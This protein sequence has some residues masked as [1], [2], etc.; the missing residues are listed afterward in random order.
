MRL[1]ITCLLPS[2]SSSFRRF[3]LYLFV[4]TLSVFNLTFAAELSVSAA[5]G[6]REFISYLGKEFENKTGSRVVFNFSSSG[7][8][9]NQIEFG[10][11]VDVYISASD[12][13]MNYLVSKGIVDKNTVFP[14]AGTELAVVTFVKSGITSLQE[15]KRIAIGDELAPVGRYAVEALKN[16]GLYGKLKNRFVFAPTVRHIAVWVITGNAD[17]GVV[18]YSDYLKFKDRLKL[19][20]ILPK[21]SHSPILFYIGLVRSTHQR[22]LA[23]KFEKFLFSVGEEEFKK[24]GFYKIKGDI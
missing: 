12:F 15:A 24:F 9:A 23:E 4:L 14:F 18:Y 6:V 17:V 11:P 10:A 22:A 20:K 1:P 2:F 16:L 21:D 7:K 13:W 3:F 5:M 8:L 19:L